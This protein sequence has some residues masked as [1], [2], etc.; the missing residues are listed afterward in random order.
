MDGARDKSSALYDARSNIM[1]IQGLLGESDIDSSLNTC[2][3]GL[4]G[5]AAFKKY[6]EET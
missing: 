1:S 6:P 5:E 3:A 2:F 4:W